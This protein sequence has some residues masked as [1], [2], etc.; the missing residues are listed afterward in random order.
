[1]HPRLRRRLLGALPLQH[2][3]GVHGRLRSAA[4]L[5]ASGPPAL[6]VAPQRIEPRTSRIAMAVGF[7]CRVADAIGVIAGN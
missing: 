4:R 2:R 1:V 3:R 5:F 7:P 6:G